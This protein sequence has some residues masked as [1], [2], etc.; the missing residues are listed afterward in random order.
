MAT[1]IGGGFRDTFD[2]LD[3][4]FWYISD[5]TNAENWINTAWDPANATVSGGDLS[6]GLDTTDQDGKSYTGAEIQSNGFY[7]YGRYDVT[8]QASGDTGVN[9]N[10]FTYTGPSFGDAWNEIDFEFLGKDPTKVSLTYHTADGSDVEHW[11]DLGF[12][13][14]AGFHA[15]SIIW[16][17][18][19]IQWLADGNVLYEVQNPALAVPDTAGKFMMN[20][21]TGME[22]W[23][24]TPT[25][26][27]P[28]SAI[29][30]DV[31]YTPWNGA[32]TYAPPA[33]IPDRDGAITAWLADADSGEII[34]AF[35]DGVTFDAGN[36]AGRN[37]TIYAEVPGDS[38][39]SGTVESMVLDFDDGAV[40][41]TENLSPYALF[42]DSSATGLNGGL[43][44]DSGPHEI[45][46]A[47][48]SAD[49]ASGT[50]LGLADY[51]FEVSDPLASDPVP[52]VT[53]QQDIADVPDTI[54]HVEAPPAA[55]LVHGAAKA[56]LGLTMTNDEPDNITPHAHFHNSGKG[57]EHEN[58]GF[59]HSLAPDIPHFEAMDIAHDGLLL[60]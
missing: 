21:W 11:V 33:G 49:H 60:I 27:D 34:G 25:F 31:S 44:L 56:P 22:G 30:S 26:T 43:S 24:G 35:G 50:Y 45:S 51:T 58:A 9:S 20:I 17:P 19:S 46:F 37:L 47:L 18:N 10:F 6:L 52:I 40:V 7:G 48:Y 41:R 12:D 53:D 55:I 36:L 59:G 57:Q 23:L 15:Y 28:A 14:S 1:L 5:Y 4:S 42:G 38:P 29:Y 8:M 16:E 2:A 3:R 13:A 32:Y 54:A 39:L